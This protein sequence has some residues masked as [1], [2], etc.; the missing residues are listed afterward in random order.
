MFWETV[1]VGEFNVFISEMVIEELNHCDPGKLALLANYLSEVE[2]SVLGLNDEIKSLATIIIERSIL[3]KRSLGDSFHIA[4]AL[5]AECDLLLTWNMKHL[6]NFY[7]NR[8]IRF[9]TLENMYKPLS[10]MPPSMLI[11]AKG[12]TEDDK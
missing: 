10:I 11:E 2:H 8:E 12:E 1:K 4:Y 7:T 6:A 5:T 3:P 9:L